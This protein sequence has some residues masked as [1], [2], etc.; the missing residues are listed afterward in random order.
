[1]N[2]PL[3]WRIPQPPDGFWLD[4]AGTG[5]PPGPLPARLLY[6]RGITTNR[7]ALEYLHADLEGLSSPFDLPDVDQAASRLLSAAAAGERIG[8]FGDFDVDGLTGTAIL[9]DAVEKLGGVPLPYIPHRENEG[10][11]LSMPALRSLLDGGAALIVTVDTGSTA[12]DEV[13]AAHRAGVDTIITDH[14]VPGDELPA[15]AA[16]VNP[17]IDGRTEADLTGAGVAFM[18]ARAVFELA[19]SQQ[20]AHH[21]ALA[22]LGSIADRG[23]LQGDNR[24]ITRSGLVE[25]GRTSHPG[26]AALLKI[27]GAARTDDNPTAETVSF[28]LAPRLN[29]PGRLGDAA[30]SF[31]LLTETDPDRAERLAEWLDLKNRERRTLG[32]EAFRQAREQVSAQG[33][34]AYVAVA[35]LQDVR[36]GLLGPLAGRLCDV[37]SKPAIA[38]ACKD[39]VARASARSVPEFDV[40]AAIKTSEPLLSHFGGHPRAA[41]FATPAASLQQVLDSVEHQAAWSLMGRTRTQ[42]LD[43]DAEAHL[44]ELGTATWDFIDMMAPFGPGNPEPLLAFRNLKVSNVRT[45][46]AGNRH[47]RV[48]LESRGARYSA[49]GF[50][51]GDA[52]LGRATVDAVCSLT[53]NVWAG[54]RTRELRIKDIRPSLRNA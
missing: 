31:E 47:L 46:G 51:L 12:V 38:V 4:L 27:S 41:G 16:I 7:Q 23:P 42:Y 44:E 11:G 52:N 1:M 39:G 29:A 20:P 43:V 6:N 28:Q 17:A 3:E 48:D 53:W 35:A 8:I 32:E 2:D 22:A 15:A 19:G 45:V 5:A 34:Q 24:C 25:L 36:I 54:R 13:D 10:H 49:I 50:G 33:E 18:L 40:H 26:L 37:Y 30:P 9:A 21:S 14:H